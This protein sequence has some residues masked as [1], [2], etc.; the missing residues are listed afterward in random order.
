MKPETL[1][2]IDVCSKALTKPGCS[3]ATSMVRSAGFATW[4]V[5]WEGPFF[6][7]ATSWRQPIVDAAIKKSAAAT[8][9]AIGRKARVPYGP[10]LWAADRVTVLA[11][12]SGCS[13]L[14][15]P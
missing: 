11:G 7:S 12:V 2:K 4:I 9:H 8:A 10:E 15:V 3:I 14:P 13:A 1:E 6:F 5:G